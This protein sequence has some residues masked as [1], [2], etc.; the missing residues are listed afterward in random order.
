MGD[1]KIRT[2]ETGQH[3]APRREG[4]RER[5]T[6]M[7]FDDEE[8]PEPGDVSGMAGEL[9]DQRQNP[10]NDEDQDGQQRRPARQTCRALRWTFGD[11]AVNHRDTANG[12]R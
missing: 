2:C 4:G 8:S 3:I 5:L 11:G 7:R 10:H 1:I 6:W 9:I 12:R